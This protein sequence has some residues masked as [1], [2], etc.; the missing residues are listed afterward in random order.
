MAG[1]MFRIRTKEV[2]VFDGLSRPGLSV[3][4]TTHN[5][6][7][8]ILAISKSEEERVSLGDRERM[9]TFNCIHDQ[10]FLLELDDSEENLRAAI[11]VFV[12]MATT[13]TSI[14]SQ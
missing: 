4:Q 6:W 2:E 11:L 3:A 13:I 9:H 1:Q 8:L 5:N 7:L 14:C 12:S 10:Q